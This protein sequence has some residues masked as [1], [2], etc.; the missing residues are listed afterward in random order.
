MCHTSVW[1]D[2]LL[3]GPL[4]S[5][6]NFNRSPIRETRHLQPS[7][8]A[9]PQWPNGPP[10]PSSITAAL[11]RLPRRPIIQPCGPGCLFPRAD[12]TCHTKPAEHPSAVG[13][14][15]RFAPARG[16][17][18]YSAQGT[19]PSLAGEHLASCG[20]CHMGSAFRCIRRPSLPSLAL[21]G[22]M[23]LNGRVSSWGCHAKYRGVRGSSVGGALILDWILD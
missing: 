1:T 12:N 3:W 14:D 15:Y 10:G 11:A 7:E 16:R 18:T 22:V 5:S 21:R 13:L 8:R 17:T 19:K 23:I 6:G 20:P 4:V 9:S 2:Y